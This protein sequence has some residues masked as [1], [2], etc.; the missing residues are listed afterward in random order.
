VPA[1]YP[2]YLFPMAISTIAPSDTWLVYNNLVEHW[3][4]TIWTI[5]D[6][7][8]TSSISLNG[9]WV[10]P[11]GD[12]WVT[13]SDGVIKRWHA[14]AATTLNIGAYAGTI[15]GTAPNDVFVTSIGHL[16]H[17]DGTT[18][19][20]IYS[21]TKTAGWYQGVKGDVWISGASAAI[22]HWDGTTLT[23]HSPAI[24]SQATVQ[25]AEYADVNDVSWLASGATAAPSTFIHWDGAQL[26]TTPIALASTPLGDP[27]C[28]DLGSVRVINGQWWIVCDGGAIA[29]KTG[30]NTIGSVIA[31]FS[32]TGGLWGASKNDLYLAAGSDVRHW[33]GSTWTHTP[34]PVSGLS[35]L[36]GTG[37]GGADEL[38]GT[39]FNFA[40]GSYTT[41]LDHFDGASWTTTPLASFALGGTLQFIATV[42]PL[43]PDE[44]MLVGGGGTAFHYQSGS[45]SAVAPGT[46]VDLV[47]IWGPDSDHLSITGANGTLLAWDRASPGVFTLDSSAPTTTDNFGQI[48]SAGGTTWIVPANQTYVWMRPS[49]GSWQTIPTLVSPLSI[50][51][52]NDHD[53]V[54]GASDSGLVARWNGAAFA[55][56]YYPSWRQLSGLFALPDGTT[57][58]N[59]E[60][61]IVVHP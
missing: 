51:A 45:V 31:P 35:G 60:S 22:F 52:I 49:G 29:T 18:F 32:G 28:A 47:G 43:G 30:A 42:Y 2:S 11:T 55:I 37:A 33:N 14:G 53:V 21:G 54:V 15:W 25:S 23:D 38:F 16:Y 59:G 57:Y 12:A 39:H 10:D 44:A 40:A 50:V 20:I 8:T 41:Y 17:Y 26:T 48:A 13:Q 34:R 61:G 7:Q 1:G 27:V 19:S 5:V 58:L 46:T 9:V 36:A 56:E 24:T 4:G 6:T 3:D